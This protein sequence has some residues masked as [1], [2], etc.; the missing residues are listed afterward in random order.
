MDERVKLSV[1]SLIKYS[2]APHTEGTITWDLYI[3]MYI[4]DGGWK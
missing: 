1:C 3:K 4:Q 2:W